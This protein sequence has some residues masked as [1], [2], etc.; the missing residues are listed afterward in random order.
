MKLPCKLIEDLLPL[1]HDNVCSAESRELVEE[2]LSGCERCAGQLREM[3][4][5]LNAPS[6]NRDELKPLRE[7]R[8]E[9]IKVKKRSLL[10]GI[11]ITLLSVLVVIGA[12]KG[13][14]ELYI[15]PISTERIEISD[16]SVTKEGAVAFHLYIAGGKPLYELSVRTDEKSGTAYI[17][18]KRA[19]IEKSGAPYGLMLLNDQYYYISFS[20]FSKE[21]FNDPA[22]ESEIIEYLEQH[23]EIGKS[24]YTFYS[25]TIKIYIGTENDNILLWEKGME[26]PEANEQVQECFENGIR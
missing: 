12:Y 17:T 15:F 26:L 2:H 24:E 5:E 16:V 8:S 14:T 11:A 1:Y 13:L 18:P 3:D 22:Y 21:Q 9:W 25:D 4:A 6:E 10:K 20:P 23:D 7:I 19:A